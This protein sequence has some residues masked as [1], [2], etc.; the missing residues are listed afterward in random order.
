MAL[1]SS[2]R[3][4]VAFIVLILLL[5]AL[6]GSALGEVL[7]LILPDGVVKEF[8][9]GSHKWRSRTNHSQRRSLYH[10]HRIHHQIKRD[11]YRG[12]CGCGLSSALV[13]EII[14]I[15]NLSSYNYMSLGQY[16]AD[17]LK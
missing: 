14:E 2:K 6:V 8:F 1:G 7:A 11:R 13:L 15:R 17:G 16:S 3:K 9:F 10:Y 4:S 5:G 12:Y